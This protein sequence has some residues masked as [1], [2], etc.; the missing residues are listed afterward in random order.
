MRKTPQISVE[1]LISH[2]FLISRHVTSFTI[3]YWNSILKLF[4]IFQFWSRKLQ[5]VAYQQS[6]LPATLQH[7]IRRRFCRRRKRC[8]AVSSVWGLGLLCPVWED[9]SYA[10]F[11]SIGSFR[12]RWDFLVFCYIH[13][14]SDMDETWETA[15]QNLYCLFP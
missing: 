4:D 3:F 2:T 6:R 5:L 10:C 14:Y 11:N 1:S 8:V 15:V 9:W 13:G 12:A 7:N